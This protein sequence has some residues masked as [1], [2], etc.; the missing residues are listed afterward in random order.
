MRKFLTSVLSI[1]IIFSFCHVYADKSEIMENIQAIQDCENRSGLSLEAVPAKKLYAKSS[2]YLN[3]AASPVNY[4]N[5]YI[6]EYIKQQCLNHAEKIYIEQFNLTV[7]EVSALYFKTVFCNPELMIRTICSYE[8]YSTGI[9]ISIIPVYIF[10]T[11]EETNQAVTAMNS[12]IDEYVRL[13]E[14]FDD[15]VEKI[16]SV[17]DEM[18]KRCSY[19]HD[20]AATPS[21]YNDSFHAYGFFMNNTAVCQGYAQAFFAIAQKLGIDAGFCQSDSAN[22]IWN[23]VTIDNL[24]YHIDVTHDDPDSEFNGAYHKN[25]LVCDKTIESNGGHSSKEEWKTYYDELPDCS[26]DKYENNY[27]FNIGASCSIEY[28][29]SGYVITALL[30]GLNLTFRSDGLKTLGLLVSDVLSDDTSDYFIIALT[31]SKPL[32][33][34]I[35]SSSFSD[36][37]LLWLTQN[38]RS[39]SNKYTFYGHRFINQAGYETQFFFWDS[40]TQTPYAVPKTIK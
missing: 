22:H 16:L 7:P 14:Q 39:I 15:P 32:D 29:D 9:V 38:D 30:N 31:D 34:R 11:K 18:T 20:A 23:Y 4:D 36:G 25:F 17:H 19:N 27:I 13:A 33:V 6:Y 37:K 35:F 5:N 26:S 1:F 21:A 40:K 28:T 3:S 24:T 8:Y 12:V 2:L 10:D